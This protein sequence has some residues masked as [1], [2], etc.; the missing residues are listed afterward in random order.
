M[1]FDPDLWP[2][3]LNINRDHLLIKDYLP[4]K[5]E[6][7]RMNRFWVISCTKWRETHI[8][9]DR[10]TA[11]QTDQH[12]QS[13]MPHLFQRGHKCKDWSTHVLFA[14]GNERT[15]VM[16]KS[17]RSASG[18]KRFT[19]DQCPIISQFALSKSRWRSIAFSPK[20]MLHKRGLLQRNIW[21]K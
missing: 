21:P 15:L 19:R 10:R 18:F 1:T 5:F 14:L 16:C 7:C 8:P 13:N 12:V 3:D 17:L 4:T 11:G 9:T 2:T 6:A 20:I